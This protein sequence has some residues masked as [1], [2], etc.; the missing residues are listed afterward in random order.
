MRKF[1]K[2]IADTRKRVVPLRGGFFV[3]VED[4]ARIHDLLCFL[5]DIEHVL[6]I[7]VFKPWTHH[8]VSRGIPALNHRLPSWLVVT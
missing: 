4:A 6:P 5:K 1:L 7:H 2:M 3:R 8:S